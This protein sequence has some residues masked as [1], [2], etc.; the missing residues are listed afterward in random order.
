[1]KLLL[2]RSSHSPLY[3]Q[4]AEQIRTQILQGNL[5]PGAAVP[6][7]R[8]LAK[9]LGV[10]ALTI[11][12]AYEDLKRRGLL[13]AF[14][15]QS[16]RVATK[17]AGL[18]GRELLAGLPARGPMAIFE[19]ASL[20]IGMRSMASGVA[21]PDL[22][23]ADA[24]LA[25]L[26]EAMLSDSW[27]LYYAEPHG[28]TELLQQIAVLLGQ[29]GIQANESACLVTNGSLQ[30]LD[31]LC[32]LLC[33][34]GDV[35]LVQEPGRLW[36]QQLLALKHLVGVPVRRMG[37][38]LDFDH[39]QHCM[40]QH[41]PKM[42]LLSPDYGH[43]TG[44]VMPLV[45]RRTC[46]ELCMQAGVLLVEDGSCRALD[47][48]DRALPP[49][50]AEAQDGVAYI[51]SFSYSLC[52][53]LSTGF[54]RMPTPLLR[55]ASTLCEALSL[56]GSQFLQAALARYLRQG[57]QEAH[58][59]RVLPKYRL[60]RDALL[61]SFRNRMPS[62]VQWTEPE[63]GFSSWLTLEKNICS[64]QLYADAVKRGI[65]FAPGNLFLTAD[66]PERQLRLS[67]GLLQPEAIV[68]AVGTLAALLKSAAPR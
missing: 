49:I 25:E 42:V 29:I 57:L 62:W 64:S 24:L 21:D 2:D 67:F 36:L 7:V 43:G 4:I 58:L 5:V 18:P 63:G 12:R 51:G 47:Y 40:I 54:V 68:S 45:E 39:L 19:R 66:D 20:G 28:A 10:S 53:G 38:G 32:S 11:S 34:P 16:V 1:M 22:F 9:E 56:S 60:R 17:F 26:R 48:D 3:R 27:N 15:R 59:K 6:P 8:R 52:P 13:E 14:S 31:I 65:T 61:S 35:I 50:A 23:H 30:A 44:L 37:S 46:L 33:R 55:S 41:K